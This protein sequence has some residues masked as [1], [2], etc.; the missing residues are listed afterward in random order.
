[1]S[2]DG[3]SLHVLEN[4]G[5]GIE[6]RDNTDEFTDQPIT[7]IVE[8]AVADQ[9]KPLARGTSEH[10]I[11][12]TTADSGRLCDI[13]ATES[14]DWARYYCRLR[15]VVLV[16]GAMHRVPLHSRDHVEPGLLE[17]EAKPPGPCE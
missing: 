10:A 14:L 9:G 17:T 15:K 13:V 3:K 5:P 8:K 1:M 7:G 16:N 6:L 11:D 2:A 4:E 12:P